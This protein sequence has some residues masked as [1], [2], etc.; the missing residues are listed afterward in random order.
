MRKSIA[1]SADRQELFEAKTSATNLAAYSNWF[2][3]HCSDS[4]RAGLNQ[5][6]LAIFSRETGSAELPAHHGL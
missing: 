2:R 6:V 3:R 4:V 5:A 1:C